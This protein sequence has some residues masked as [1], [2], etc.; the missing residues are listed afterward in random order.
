[1]AHATREQSA[2]ADNAEN[3]L[4]LSAD[5]GGVLSGQLEAVYLIKR[6]VCTR[7]AII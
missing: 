1:V 3:V 6:V 7:L 2:L 5:V 4:F